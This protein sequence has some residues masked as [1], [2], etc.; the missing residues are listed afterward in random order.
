VA[1]LVA[2]ACEFGAAPTCKTSFLMSMNSTG[3]WSEI[4]VLTGITQTINSYE[5]NAITLA[6]KKG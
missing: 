3:G 6:H 1:Q 2:L 5:H 4:R